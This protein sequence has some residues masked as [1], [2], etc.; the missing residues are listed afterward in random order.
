MDLTHLSLDIQWYVSET[1]NFDAVIRSGTLRN[2]LTALVRL[3]S[4]SLRFSPKDSIKRGRSG[5]V[6]T[7]YTGPRPRLRDVMP[8]HKNWPKLQKLDMWFVSGTVDELVGLRRQYATTVNELD[9]AGIAMCR[10]DGRRELD[11]RRLGLAWRSVAEALEGVEYLRRASLRERT[12]NTAVGR[13]DWWMRG[14]VVVETDLWRYLA[15]GV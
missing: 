13:W 6:A 4:P 11:D 14:C 10:R 3:E 1:Y 5:H 8:L 2:L 7:M 9:L 15:H 12:E